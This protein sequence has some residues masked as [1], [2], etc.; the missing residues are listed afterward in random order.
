MGFN[1]QP[2]FPVFPV[3][4]KMPVVPQM[5]MVPQ[6]HFAPNQ[7]FIIYAVH[8]NSLK[9][10]DVA[11]DMANY[12]NL[13][14]YSFHGAPNQR[15]V[16]E[17]DG[18]AYRIKSV[19]SGKYVRVTN[20]DQHDNMWIR[21]DDKGNKSEL[22]TIVAA[23]SPQYAGKKAYHIKSI[24]GKALE[25]PQGK[26]DNSTKIQQGSFNGSEGQTWIIKEI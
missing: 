10:I 17:Q 26:L 7:H 8:G 20:D 22:W 19:A 4:P 13:I 14:L 15:F 25:T 11:Q 5:P 1:Q 24:F 9:C 16:F 18:A 12:G 23:T 3:A 2:T 21:T 6:V